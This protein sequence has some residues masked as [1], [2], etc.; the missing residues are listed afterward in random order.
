[1]LALVISLGVRDLEHVW[2]HGC[3]VQD[4]HFAPQ[5]LLPFR[6][7]G[8][9]PSDLLGFGG[10]RQAAGLIHH[11]KNFLEVLKVP[12]LL[13]LHLYHESVLSADWTGQGQAYLA[14]A[15]HVC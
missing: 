12:I 4:C 13:G 2:V 11:L 5:S 3:V 7:Y 9:L 15:R 14:W 8:R 1:M 10:L 6:H